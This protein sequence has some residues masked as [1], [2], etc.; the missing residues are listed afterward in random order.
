MQ[1][2]KKTL[3]NIFLG[4]AACI[5]LVW[6]LYETDR[7]LQLLYK[8]FA[9]ISPFLV[10]A[11]MA[12][13]FN[14]PMRA[15]EK[16]L[17]FIRKD[18]LRR[19]TAV[20]LTIVVI[21]I[22]LAGVVLLLLPQLIETIG[23][24]IDQIP[25]FAGHVIEMV[26]Q[27]LAEH[28]E[29]QDKLNAYTDFENINWSELFQNVMSMFSGSLS[30]VADYMYLAISGMT[31]VI[32]NAVLSFAFCFYCLF[33]KEILAR[34]ARRILYSFLPEKAC[35][36]IVR[37]MRM[38]S[39]SFSRF[40]SGQ[41]LEAVILACMF[42]VAM[43]IFR[44]PY[45]ALV[46]VVIG[47]TALVPIVGAFVGCFVGAFFILVHDPMTAVWFVVLF[48]VLQQIEG[49]LIYPK[50]IG[51]SVGLPGMWVLVAVGVGSDLM[52]IAGM[53]I[54]IPVGSVLYTLVREITDKR[55]AARKIAEDKL[56]YY[57]TDTTSKFKEKRQTRKEKRSKKNQKQADPQ[58]TETA[59]EN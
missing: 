54:M 5:L 58:N 46:S 13:I 38:T 45:V 3:R 27:F 15:I 35:D 55:L 18:G 40:L 44:M 8:G 6:F 9:I 16:L 34:Q 14:V 48:L 17:K 39:S 19:A 37:I 24:L 57:P 20:V 53:L 59:Q 51:T 36:E 1:I 47:I 29:L 56:Q 33:R 42:A 49:N 30:S 7:A 21:C 4:T 41:C 32:F 10:G 12:F 52:G 50:V 26:N 43:S 11:A 22:V 23:T 25:A 31:S 28:P 2:E